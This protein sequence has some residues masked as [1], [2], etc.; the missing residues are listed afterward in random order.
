MGSSGDN[1]LTT[2]TGWLTRGVNA[3]LGTEK[4]M[5]IRTSQFLLAALLMLASVGVLY[6]MRAAGIEGMGDV[7]TW[8][9]F[10]CGGLVVIYALIRS[11]FSL[12]MADP[13]LAFWQM[14]YAIACNAAAFIIAG[15]GR[16]VSLPILSVILMFGMF[17]LSMRQVIFVAVYGV[18][19][20]VWA[21]AYTLKHLAT[22]ESVD[23]LAA[24][25]FMV[26]VVLSATTFL[27]WRLQQMSAHMRNQKNQLALALDKIGQ[28]ATRDDLTGIA[29]R[30]FMLEKIQDEIQRAE[31]TGQPLLLAMLDID[32]FKQINDKHGHP[33]GD[34]VLQAFVAVVQSAIRGNDTLARWGGEEFVILLT[35]TE[36]S[37]GLVCLERVLAK[38]AEAEILA[39]DACLKLT[40]SIGVTP[41]HDRDGFEKTMARA[42]TA[43]YQAKAQGRNRLVWLDSPP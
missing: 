9:A 33:A 35:E 19:L 11:S 10:S 6:F 14:L 43:L 20:F 7:D 1:N 16:G 4:A 31:R 42:D 34:L 15:H 24:Y 3:L 23:L 30:R 29:N 36:L 26:F 28:I 18:F 13:S 32:H 21:A 40:V 27:T 38:V 12:R 17:G 25:V 37:V 2:S 41:Y 22:N 39:G 5:R 8:A